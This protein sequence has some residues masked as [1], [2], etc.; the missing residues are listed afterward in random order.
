MIL[1]IATLV[2]I[3]FTAVTKQF[4]APGLLVSGFVCSVKAGRLN[5][6]VPF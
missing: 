6:G 5:A 3:F 4:Y 2:I 1:L